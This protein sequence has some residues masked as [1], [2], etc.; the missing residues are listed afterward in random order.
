MSNREDAAD[1]LQDVGMIILAHDDPPLDSDRFVP[2]CMGIARNTVLHHW[3]RVRRYD[4]VFIRWDVDDSDCGLAFFF[5]GVLLDR[6]HVAICLQGLDE[7]SR[8]LLFLRYVMGK[9]SR[10]IAE[11][12]GQSPAAVRMRIMRVREALREGWRT[13]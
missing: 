8:S 4:E 7:P 11:E 13:K 10:E 1:L 12:L 5:E 9:T 6:Q 2:W 3:R